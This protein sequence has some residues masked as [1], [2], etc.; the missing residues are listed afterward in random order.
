MRRTTQRHTQRLI[1]AIALHTLAVLARKKKKSPPDGSDNGGMF[2]CTEIYI[3]GYFNNTQ[4]NGGIFSGWD[5]GQVADTDNNGVQVPLL[6]DFLTGI[7]EPMPYMSDALAEIDVGDP[8]LGEPTFYSW[9]NFNKKNKHYGYKAPLRGG[10]NAANRSED[11]TW[12]GGTVRGDVVTVTTDDVTNATTGIRVVTETTT[13]VI[14]LTTEEIIQTTYRPDD[15]LQDNWEEEVYRRSSTRLASKP[16]ADSAEKIE[17]DASGSASGS[18]RLLGDD[19]DGPAVVET[20]NLPNLADTCGEGGDPNHP[21]KSQ[22]DHPY[23]VCASRTFEWSCE[24][25]NIAAVT[26]RMK[27]LKEMQADDCWTVN[28]YDVKC[29]GAPL[30]AQRC[31]LVG[32]EIQPGEHV[33]GVQI[34]VDGDRCR[35]CSMNDDL[36]P[37]YYDVHSCT[38]EFLRTTN[39]ALAQEGYYD[40]DG[41]SR[42]DNPDNDPNAANEFRVIY[43]LN[44]GPVAASASLLMSIALATLVSLFSMH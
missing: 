22:L 11:T 44:S 5:W 18:R 27:E 32:G 13:E 14:T 12:E 24:M 31:E 30:G 40:E 9:I 43:V 29:E 16:K 28:Q 19:D 42:E 25:T 7:C 8:V 6:N 10:P 1:L 15:Q 38:Y 34:T 39:L 41:E 21:D 35:A 37:S 33:V 20:T 2:T 17:P 3:Y 23:P 36:C 26:Q 4:A